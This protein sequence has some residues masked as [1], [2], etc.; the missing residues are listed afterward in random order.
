MG[1]DRLIPRVDFSQIGIHGR[2]MT[3]AIEISIPAG[4]ILPRAIGIDWT[5]VE[6]PRRT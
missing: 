2:S 4:V 5:R 1:K 6:K 3:I